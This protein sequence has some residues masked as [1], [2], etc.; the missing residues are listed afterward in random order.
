MTRILHFQ[1][2]K[3]KAKPFPFAR[4]YLKSLADQFTLM[5]IYFGFASSLFGT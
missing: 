1:K 5:A 3:G 2:E 4:G